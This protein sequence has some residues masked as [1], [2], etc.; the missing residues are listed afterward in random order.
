MP[1]VKCRKCGGGGAIRRDTCKTCNGAGRIFKPAEKV[2][3][4]D[5]VIKPAELRRDDYELTLP[6][7]RG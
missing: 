7:G 6:R 3:D 5:V 1:M 2:S 4:R